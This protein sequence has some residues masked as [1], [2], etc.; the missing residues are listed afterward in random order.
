MS[1]EGFRLPGKWKLRAHGRSIVLH[2]LGRDRP[3]HGLMKALIWGLYLPE[4]PTATIEIDVGD[5]YKPD[6]VALDPFGKPLLWGESG[7]VSPKKLRDLAKRYRSARLV[8]AKWDASL[9]QHLVHIRKA[10]EGVER[11]APFDVLSFPADSLE[12]F[13]TPD[14][15]IQVSFSDLVW[16]QFD[17][18]GRVSKELS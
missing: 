13:I 17:G 7:Q 16:T 10:L 2:S 4:F 8:V 11:T 15:E 6:V 12:R 9:E 5:R 1:N 18:A 14:G 3:S